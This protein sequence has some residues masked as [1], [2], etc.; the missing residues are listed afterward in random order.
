LPSAI[1]PTLLATS[2][3]F[4]ISSLQSAMLSA[5]EAATTRAFQSVPRHLRRRAAS[6][7]PRRLP[8]RLRERAK[9]EM[10]A[11]K[12]VTKGSLPR[13]GKSKK[14]TQAQ[15]FAKRQVDKTWLETHLFHAKRTHMATLYS[16]RLALTPTSK[17]YR[18][19]QR[20]ARQGSILHDASY[21]ATVEVRGREGM[22]REVLGRVAAPG[23]G[24]GGGGAGPGA[25]RYVSGS[26]A[27]E[28][29]AR[30]C[31]EEVLGPLGVIWRPV[32]PDLGAGA[33]RRLRTLWLRIH[34]AIFPPFLL[35]LQSACSAVLEQ[36]RLS[37][38]PGTAHTKAEE[39]TLEIQD[40]RG[41]VLAFDLMGPRSTQVL[42]GA[43]GLVKGEERGEVK[44]VW[45]ELQSLGSP[46]EVPRGLILGL[47]VYD[48]RLSFPPKNASS[49]S[50]S[51]PFTHF[52]SSLLAQSRLWDPAHRA[53]PRFRKQELDARRAKQLV[54]GTP[55]RAGA[56]DGRVPVLLVQ[57]TVGSSAAGGGKEEALHGWTLLFPKGWGMAFLPSLLSSGTLLAGQR[58]VHQ[59]AFEAGVP[60]FPRDWITTAAG[61]REWEEWGREEADKWA[62]RPPG[63]RVGEEGCWSADWRGVLGLRAQEETLD[64]QRDDP[65]QDLALKGEGPRPWMLRL[66][67]L[68]VLLQNMLHPPAGSTA[69]GSLPAGELLLQSALVH[70]RVVPCARGCPGDL[71]SLYLL[72]QAEASEWR[73]TLSP[74]V[75]DKLAEEEEGE[76]AR[77]GALPA[78]EEARM[79]YVTT[80]NFSL[81]RGRGHALGAVSLRKLLLAGS[82]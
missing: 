73:A 81:L 45:N 77:L 23:G 18:P 72:S 75:G 25:V 71:A 32:T 49:S 76:L 56:A 46:G 40:L 14:E 15:K 57:R 35:S 29:V 62:R 61:V 5:Q 12:R 36:H 37:S 53:P 16:H 38:P 20:A 30:A 43:L 80:G 17:S 63:K 64:T 54:P 2:R 8:V 52:P 65:P 11:P 28:G 41:E 44:E 31:G 10:D 19:S 33:G 78:R 68:A 34:P 26:R 24:G 7:D 6:H 9:A 3:E 13:L 70:V 42:R 82:G 67:E 51:G 59:Q 66:P 27:W 1:D 60:H 21:F 50:P 47:E 48:P 55:L 79:G 4:E 22:L 58:E 69:A 39:E 74:S